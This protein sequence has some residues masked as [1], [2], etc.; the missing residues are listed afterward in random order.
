M[1]GQIKSALAAVLTTSEVGDLRR[2]AAQAIA[3]V[4]L[5]DMQSKEWPELVP[6]L[7]KFSSPDSGAR[8]GVRCN[9]LE[10]IGYVCEELATLDVGDENG[11]LSQQEVNSILNAVVK[12]IGESGE[13]KAC[14]ITKL[15]LLLANLVDSGCRK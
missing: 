2:G 3:K 15:C 4:A 11:I 5:M 9:T 7:L 12:S 6:L 8:N 10:A 1:R 13:T 14:S